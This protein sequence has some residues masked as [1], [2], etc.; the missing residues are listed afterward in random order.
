MG[1][2]TSVKGLPFAG[3]AGTVVRGARAVV[4]HGVDGLDDKFVLVADDDNE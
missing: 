3:P 1:R 4:S 2:E